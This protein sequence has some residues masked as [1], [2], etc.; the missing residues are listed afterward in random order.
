MANSLCPPRRRESSE[1]RND[2]CAQRSYSAG[3]HDSASISCRAAH[4]ECRQFLPLPGRARAC[5][6]LLLGA[7]RRRLR[8]QRVWRNELRPCV[9]MRS[10]RVGRVFTMRDQTART[11]L[12][13][14]A[15]GGC[16][17]GAVCGCGAAA[18]GPATLPCA[19][20]FAP[21]P[22]AHP[23]V[24][25]HALSFGWI[26]LQHLLRQRRGAGVCL[27]PVQLG[28]ATHTHTRGHEHRGRHRGSRRIRAH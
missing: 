10:L 9:C 16:G 15:R 14:D 24:L 1:P 27:Q 20:D 26:H 13:P 18:V 6:E 11:I 23:I 8:M 7:L 17:A 4:L 3:R 21:L 5:A 19:A 22:R 2:R 25:P 12:G 28:S